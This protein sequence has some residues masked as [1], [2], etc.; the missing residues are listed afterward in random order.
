MSFTSSLSELDATRMCGKVSTGSLRIVVA[1]ILHNC[2]TVA[3]PNH[4]HTEIQHIWE[5]EAIGPRS[6]ISQK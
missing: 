5:K 1:G 6:K 2:E 4:A 3:V